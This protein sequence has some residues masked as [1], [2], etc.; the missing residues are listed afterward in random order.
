MNALVLHRPN[1]LPS[2][3]ELFFAIVFNPLN[4]GDELTIQLA[5]LVDQVGARHP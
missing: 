1:L 5:H 2:D 3:G 4:G